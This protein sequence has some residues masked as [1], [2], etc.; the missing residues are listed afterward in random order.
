MMIGGF[1]HLLIVLVGG[2]GRGPT[3][4]LK[5][6]RQEEAEIQGMEMVGSMCFQLGVSNF[7]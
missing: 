7:H 5:L 3:D 4:S 6:M 2:R 1:C